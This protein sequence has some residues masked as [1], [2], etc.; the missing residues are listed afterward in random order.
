MVADKFSSALSFCVVTF[1][2][3]VR[4]LKCTKNVNCRYRWP[5]SFRYAY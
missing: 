4:Y 2:F 5:R 1:L 3:A